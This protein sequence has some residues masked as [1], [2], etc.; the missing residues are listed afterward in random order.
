MPKS[1]LFEMVPVAS[2]LVQSKLHSTSAHKPAKR[3]N[4]GWTKGKVTVANALNVH[5]N[6]IPLKDGSYETHYASTNLSSV[7]LTTTLRYYDLCSSIVEG[8][9]FNNRT[10]REI[11][12]YH[13]Q[14]FGQLIGGQSN[15]AL[16]DQRNCCRIMLVEAQTGL[17][18]FPGFGLVSPFDPRVFA[19]CTRVLFDQM[20][21]LISPGRDTT[22]YMPAGYMVHIQQSLKQKIHFT[23]ASTGVDSG[24]TVYLLMISDS[25][26]VPSPGFVNGSFQV[27]WHDL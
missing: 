6:A 7:T 10:G 11:D 13:F 23:G 25:S 3:R 18:T 27:M 19:G 4:K 9:D 1:Q 17:T 16:D 15:V 12:L 2:N 20:F 21:S 22:G 14:L 24:L 26:T 8:D 5:L